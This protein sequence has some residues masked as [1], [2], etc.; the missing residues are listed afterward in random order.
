MFCAFC[1][2]GTSPINPPADP[3]K[4]R[5]EN[6]AS[7]PGAQ[8]YWVNRIF[9]WDTRPRGDDKAPAPNEGNFLYQLFHT[10][11]PGS[12]DTS[13]V[14]T[15]YMNNPRTMNAVYSV[16]ARLGL[17]MET[18]AEQLT[19]GE[20]HNKQLQGYPQTAALSQFCDPLTGT[21]PTM[22]SLNAP[23]PPAGPPLALTSPSLT[24]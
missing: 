16:I 24:I 2:V 15:D 11:P 22:R 13:L 20:L 12:L 9:F 10:N 21:S 1:H 14:S 17:S 4:P 5:W 3:E 19:G 23:A 18:G 6:L 7:N 8:Y